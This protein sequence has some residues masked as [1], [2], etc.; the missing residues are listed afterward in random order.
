MSGSFLKLI[1]FI[2]LIHLWKLKDT[3]T[4]T[5]VL[6]IEIIGN[7][8]GTVFHKLRNKQI[9]DEYI[10]PLLGRKTNSS[11][12]IRLVFTNNFLKEEK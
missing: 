10:I 8:A 9:P 5:Y 11:A 2:S 6:N 1:K 3:A 7:I 12:S 4:S